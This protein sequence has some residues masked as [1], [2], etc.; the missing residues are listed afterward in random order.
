[1]ITQKA[2]C[3][4][5]RLSS[6]FIPVFSLL[7]LNSCNVD[8]VGSYY[9]F[10]GQTI[11]QYLLEDPDEIGVA[12]FYKLAEH[13]QILGLLNAYGEYTCFVPTDEAM[14]ELYKNKGVSSLEE[15]IEN[16]RE[17]EV[18]KLAY[19]HIIK[20]VILKDANFNEGIILSKTMS[21]RFISM[22]SANLNVDGY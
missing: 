12:E 5:R 10:T 22:S 21:D 18:Q 3:L 15:L 7:F 4:K 16:Y 2:L 1:M 19:D 17:D 13:T 11:G 9:T 8:D 6:L 20:D 14:F